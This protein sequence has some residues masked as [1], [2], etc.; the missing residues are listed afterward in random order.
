MRRVARSKNIQRPNSILRTGQKD[1]F[2]QKK[3]QKCPVLTNSFREAKRQPCSRFLWHNNHRYL[4]S[5]VFPATTHRKT[6]KEHG[7]EDDRLNVLKPSKSLVKTELLY[8]KSVLHYNNFL[9]YLSWLAK[10]CYAETEPSWPIGKVDICQGP[11][12]LR[13]PQIWKLMITIVLF[14]YF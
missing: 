3:V 6:I 9:K 12:I 14:D 10:A 7:Q 5:L 4:M 11:P 1:K 8:P 2:I 13:G